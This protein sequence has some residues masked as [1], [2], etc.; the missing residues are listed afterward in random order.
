MLDS[1]RIMHI[2]L[3]AFFASVEHVENP[4]LKGKLVVV[5]G[6]PDRRGVVATV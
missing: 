4:E 6:R 1:V 5:G 2:D 3:D